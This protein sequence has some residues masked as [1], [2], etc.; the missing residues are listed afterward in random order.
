MFGELQ[1]TYNTLLS[2]GKAV[3]AAELHWMLVKCNGRSK[4]INHGANGYQCFMACCRLYTWPPLIQLL[5]TT[6]GLCSVWC[7]EFVQLLAP[8]HLLFPEQSNYFSYFGEW[9][10][11]G[12]IH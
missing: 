12:T 9:I 11:P 3:Q 6:A 7:L 1:H 2:D 4:C 10:C 8:W 5:V